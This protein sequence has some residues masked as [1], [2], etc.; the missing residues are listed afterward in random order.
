MRSSREAWC[1][2]SI[3]AGLQRGL[4]H[5]TSY[6]MLRTL[7]STYCYYGEQCGGLSKKLKTEL[8]YD[9]VIPLLGIYLDK[10][11][12][13]KD[14]CT[15]MF[16][17]ALFTI[18]KTWEQPKCPLTDE[19]VKKMQYVYDGT[20][21]LLLSL[22]SRVRLCASPQTA[23]RQ[24]PPSLGFSRQEHWSGLPFPSPQWNTTQP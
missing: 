16:A 1:Y 4:G 7:N 5:E 23:A 8:P 2:H 17:V 21:P 6:R 10:T 22:F 15:P 3:K 9:P 19:W 14:T 20:L 18:A 24:A 13:Q 12:I 11:I